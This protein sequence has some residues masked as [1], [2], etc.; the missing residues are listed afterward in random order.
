MVSMML[1]N[2]VMTALESEE[3]V[4]RFELRVF[5]LA[6]LKQVAISAEDVAGLEDMGERYV[7]ETLRLLEAC[8]T[9]ADQAQAPDIFPPVIAACERFFMEHDGRAPDPNGLLGMICDCYLARGLLAEVSRQT[10]QIRGFPLLASD[11]HSEAP[12]I[13]RLV[14]VEI[15]EA[16][17]E[18]I[19]DAFSRPEIR[20]AAN[21]AYGLTGSLRATGRVSDWEASWEEQMASYGGSLGLALTNAA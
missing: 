14:G 21:G 6:S 11:P 20:F 3:A 18:I 2:R 1:R 10:L 17:D 4:D 19:E 8:V 5:D 13:R 9:A 12:I 15:A 7:R 16:L